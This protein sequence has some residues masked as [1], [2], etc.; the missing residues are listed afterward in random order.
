MMGRCKQERWLV[1]GTQGMKT[2]RSLGEVGL[3]GSPINTRSFVLKIS[4]QGRKGKRNVRDEAKQKEV[5][6]KGAVWRYF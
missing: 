1:V 2:S 6:A 5:V 3:V 4:V